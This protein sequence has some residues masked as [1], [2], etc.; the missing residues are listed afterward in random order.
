MIICIFNF[1]DNFYCYLLDVL[2]WEILLMIC[3]C[4]EIVKLFNVCWQIVFEQGQFI[5]LL[6]I[7]IGVWWV[8]E[9]GIFIGY[10]VLCMVIV[11]GEQGCFICC[12]LF[13]DY[14]LI[15]CC[16]WCE[17]VVEECI[18]LC[19][20]FVLEILCVLFDEGLVG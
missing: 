3:L 9:V 19:F 14:Y 11:F 15:V 18:E 12:D 16:Y 2:L 13:G 5:V 20:G 10:S 6:L 4:E 7:L 8:L 1:D 17:V